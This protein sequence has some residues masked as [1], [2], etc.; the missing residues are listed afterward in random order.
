MYRGGVSKEMGSLG[1]LQI[2][3][4]TDLEV[5]HI[6]YQLPHVVRKPPNFIKSPISLKKI[7][8]SRTQTFHFCNGGHVTFTDVS[9]NSILIEGEDIFEQLKINTSKFKNTFHY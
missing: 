7:F 2:S 8:F 3:G 1:N 4:D 6:R 9:S 5:Y